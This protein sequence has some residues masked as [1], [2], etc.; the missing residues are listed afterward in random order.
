MRVSLVFKAYRIGRENDTGNPSQILYEFLIS[1]LIFFLS[2]LSS[3]FYSLYFEIQISI[4]FKN[5]DK[6]IC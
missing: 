1:F 4:Q 2:I 6:I 3:K 5:F